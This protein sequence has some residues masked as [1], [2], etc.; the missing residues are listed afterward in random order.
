MPKARIK[1][2]GASEPRPATPALRKVPT[3]IRG[4]DEVTFGGLPE[5]RTTLVCGAAGCGKTL[6]GMQFL[7]RGALDRRE[8]GVFLAFEETASC[9]RSSVGSFAGSRI[10]G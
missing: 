2:N 8:P 4:F 7:V 6:L 9:A 5:G 1:R 10:A 3:G